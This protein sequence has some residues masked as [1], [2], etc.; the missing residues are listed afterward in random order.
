MSAIIIIGTFAHRVRKDGL[1]ESAHCNPE[2]VESLKY[3]PRALDDMQLTDGELYS[4]RQELM[5]L[6]HMVNPNR[7]PLPTPGKEAHVQT[8]SSS[9]M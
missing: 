7:E 1:V 4:I 8:D 9:P 5:T 3:G 2:F 6:N